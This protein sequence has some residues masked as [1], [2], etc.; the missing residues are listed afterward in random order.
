MVPVPRPG[1]LVPVTPY[2][3]M[4]PSTGGYWTCLLGVG[5]H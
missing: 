1:R 2:M 4:A 5:V 3:A